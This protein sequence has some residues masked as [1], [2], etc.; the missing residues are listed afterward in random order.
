MDSDAH[1]STQHR[2][3][4]HHVGVIGTLI[5]AT[6]VCL[7]VV[8]VARRLSTTPELLQSITSPDPRI[9][10]LLL[11]LP[12]LN[13]LC[14]TGSIWASTRQFGRIGWFEMCTVIG[15]ASLLNYLP[16]RLG[17]VGRLAYHKKV[18]KIDVSRAGAATLIQLLFSAVGLAISAG[19]ALLPQNM[20]FPAFAAI[21]FVFAIAAI[22]MTKTVCNTDPL[23]LSTRDSIVLTA[24][25]RTLDMLVWVVRY[26]LAMRLLNIDASWLT[27]IALATASQVGMMLSIVGN[28][29]GIREWLV[30]L[31]AKGLA[32]SI[33]RGDSA[34]DPLAVGLLA[35]LVNRVAELVFIVP[36]GIACTFWAARRMRLHS[37]ANTLTHEQAAISPQPTAP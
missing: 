30:G 13:L 7:A 25:W 15:S 17:L 9:V 27:A 14:T 6:L 4:S 8:V 21:G 33:D 28:G 35:D 34:S 16:M 32:N 36:V 20:V 29:L 19:A 5:G 22:I 26:Y 3:H 18:N 23:T 2:T 31:T 10:G 24:L 1:T 12:A 11:I 37:N